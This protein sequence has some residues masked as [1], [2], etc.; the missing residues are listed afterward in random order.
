MRLLAPLFRVPALLAGL[1]TLWLTPVVRAGLIGLEG[2]DIPVSVTG[3]TDGNSAVAMRADGTGFVVAYQA[4]DASGDG[5]FFKRFDANWQLVQGPVAVNTFTTNNQQT[6]SVGI[7]GSGNFV[8][9]WQ[10]FGQDAGDSASETGVYAR[11]F[12]ANGTAIDAAEFQVNTTTPSQQREPDVAVNASGQ[13][14]IAFRNGNGVSTTNILAQSYAGITVG[15]SGSPTTVGGESPVSPGPASIVRTLPAVAIDASGNYVVVYQAFGY[16]TASA[17]SFG[18]YLRQMNQNGTPVSG[19]EFQ[20]NVTTAGNQQLPDIAMDAGGSFNVVWDTDNVDGSGT[21]I[22]MRRF[23]SAG[24][25]L[26]ASP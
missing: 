22:A 13:F 7:D 20:V 23:N 14:V 5:I 8:I 24:Q 11:R 10:S 6:P 12:Q 16:D 3:G 21:A 1:F 9:T 19:S 26:S 18:I 17:D 25:T 2:T 15:G 4:P